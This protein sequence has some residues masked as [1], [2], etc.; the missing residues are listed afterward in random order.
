MACAE[1]DLVTGY[2]NFEL[3]MYDGRIGRWLSTDPGHQYASPYEAMGNNPVSTYDMKGDSGWVSIND[4]IANH[5]GYHPDI[6]D[7]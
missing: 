7:Q 2:N 3:R 4:G 1:K 5:F 6:Y